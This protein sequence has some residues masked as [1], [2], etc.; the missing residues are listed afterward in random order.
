MGPVLIKLLPEMNG[1]L[2]ASGCGFISRLFHQITKGVP[3]FRLVYIVIVP[4]KVK[5]PNLFNELIK[6]RYAIRFN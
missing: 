1:G 3:I 2:I 5:G 6:E 4:Q